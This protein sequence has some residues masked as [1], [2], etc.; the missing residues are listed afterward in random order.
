M[1]EELAARKY[2]SASA[3]TRE[4]SLRRADWDGRG[5]G[6]TAYR[7]AVRALVVGAGNRGRTGDIH[8]GKVALYH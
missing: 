7:R 2:G 6:R 5:S 3:S 4:V 8:L 1:L